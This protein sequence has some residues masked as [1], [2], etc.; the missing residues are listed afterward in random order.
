MA[1]R[2]TSSLSLNTTRDG[3]CTT[4]LGIPMSNHSFC[5]EIPPDVQPELPLVQLEAVP[6]CPVPCFP[7][8]EPHPLW[9]PPP[10]R[11]LCRARR[12]PLS[13][14]CSRLSPFPSS[15]SPSC[16]SSP[17]PSSVPFSGHAPAPQCLSC[18]EGPRAAPGSEVWP[19]QCPAQGTVTAPALLPPHGWPSPGALGLLPTC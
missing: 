13:L 14:L 8:A 15:L 16:C 7:G 1:L 19:Q 12:F 18:P 17:F 11:E 4:S 6:S 2:A 5:E 10:V 3:D 9:L